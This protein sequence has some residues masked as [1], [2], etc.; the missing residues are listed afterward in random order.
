M[1][2][3]KPGGICR[4]V[5]A[6]WLQ[7]KLFSGMCED[8]WPPISSLRDQQPRREPHG[9]DH[10]NCSGDHRDGPAVE[11]G[12]DDFSS[13]TTACVLAA[14][15]CVLAACACASSGAPRGLVRKEKALGLTP[16]RKCECSQKNSAAALP[17]AAFAKNENPA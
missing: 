16:R 12:D 4:P 17:R 1:L 3:S 11:R 2:A 10:R 15:A 7:L 13:S 6:P 8:T 14:T 5:S 9:T